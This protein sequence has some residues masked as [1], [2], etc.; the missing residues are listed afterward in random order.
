[1]RAPEPPKKPAACKSA[2]ERV[3]RAMTE[4]GLAAGGDLRALAEAEY[5]ALNRVWHEMSRIAER[6][7]LEGHKK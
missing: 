4:I 7:E 2:A 5:Y 1:M 3:R 6:L